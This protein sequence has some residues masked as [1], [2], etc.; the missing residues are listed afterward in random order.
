MQQQLSKQIIQFYTSLKVPERLLRGVEVLYPFADAAVQVVMQQFYA[1]YF[2]DTKERT[3]IFGINPVD[4][5]QVSPALIL[6]HLDNYGMI[7][8]LNT[9]SA[10]HPNCLPSSSMP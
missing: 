6:L 1:Q 4:M 7:V 2:H 10:I 3:L 9:L 8:V 5:V